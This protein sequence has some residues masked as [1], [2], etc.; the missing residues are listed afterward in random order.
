MNAMNRNEL[1]KLWQAEEAKGFQGWDFSYLAGRMAEEDLPWDYETSVKSLMDGDVVMLDMGTGG[2]SI[3]CHF[4]HRR[5]E[6]MRRRAIRPIM[7]Y[8]GRSC[9]PAELKSNSWRTMMF[10]LLKMVCLIW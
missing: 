3:C 4:L 2:E 9:R 6:R 1:R 10:C 5:A 7:S 8:A